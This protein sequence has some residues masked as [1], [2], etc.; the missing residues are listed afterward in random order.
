MLCSTV[1][2]CLAWHEYTATAQDHLFPLFYDFFGLLSNALAI[3]G[4]ILLF[5]LDITS[6]IN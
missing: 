2:V 5:G 3:T 4:I 1:I 6:L